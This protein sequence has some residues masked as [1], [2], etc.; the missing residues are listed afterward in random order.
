MNEDLQDIGQLSN[1]TVVDMELL[2]FGWKYKVPTSSCNFSTF[3]LKVMVQ[4]GQVSVETGNLP[5]MYKEGDR[6]IPLYFVVTAFLKNHKKQSGYLRRTE[7][8]IKNSMVVMR[9]LNV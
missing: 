8:R 5:F 3:P 4:S 7:E 1:I 6:N 9:L 2:L